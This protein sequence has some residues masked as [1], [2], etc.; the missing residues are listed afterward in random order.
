[1]K[2]ALREILET[3]ILTA[4]IFLLVRSVVQNFKVDGRS[5]EPTLEGGQYLLINKATY[6]HLDPELQQRVPGLNNNGNNRITY[7]F[8]APSR[9]DIVVFRYPNDPSRD[10]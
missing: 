8:G 3:I 9:G 1:M 4:I 7:V 10:F 6:W 2:S 5:M